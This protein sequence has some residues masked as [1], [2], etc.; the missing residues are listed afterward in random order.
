VSVSAVQ[1]GGSVCIAVD[2]D[3][4]G[5]PPAQRA[6]VLRR[7]VRLDESGPGSGLGLAIVV[8]L[9]REYGG[10]LS[11]TDAASGGLSARLRLPSSPA[12]PA[13]QGGA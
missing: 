2:D 5:V 4:P 3:G 6:A 11:L 1:E 13:R 7:G 9:A 8:E 10:E 12:A